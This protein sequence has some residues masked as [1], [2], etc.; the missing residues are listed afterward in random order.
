MGGDLSLWITPYPVDK[1]QIYG[2]DNFFQ[3]H[4]G[5]ILN[6]LCD[7]SH[8]LDQLSSYPYNLVKITTDKQPFE[9]HFVCNI[10]IS[11]D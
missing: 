7:N 4:V 9:S 5:P 2:V 1:I 6:D 8:L 10:F 11:Q 3:L